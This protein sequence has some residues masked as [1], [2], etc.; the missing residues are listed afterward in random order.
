VAA[1]SK[2]RAAIQVAT[3]ADAGVLDL[4]GAISRALLDE[5]VHLGQD[6]SLAMVVTNLVKL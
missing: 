1:G 4:L 6:G 5:P 3:E 2:Q